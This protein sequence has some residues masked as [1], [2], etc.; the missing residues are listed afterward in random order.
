MN[1]PSKGEPSL[2]SLLGSLASDTGTLV[3]QEIHLATT[4][5]TQKA[6]RAGHELGVVA[7]G[8]ALAHAGL[9]FVM[10]AVVL[11]LGTFLPM[12]AAALGLGLV[13]FAAGWAMVSGGLR[14]LRAVDPLPQRTIETLQQDKT[15]VKEQI[16]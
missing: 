14:A 8:G 2:G 15:W 12:W 10:A 4:E 3:R 1:E 11:G 5:M 13:A 6:R 16:R 7:M 9:L